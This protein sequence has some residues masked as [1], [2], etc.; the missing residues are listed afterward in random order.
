MMQVMKLQTILKNMNWQKRLARMRVVFGVI[1][2]L[3]PMLIPAATVNVGDYATLTTAIASGTDGDTI[4]FTNNITVSAEV[5][6]NAKGLTIE[7]NNH[8]ISVPVPGLNDSGVTNTSPSVFRV[9]NINASGKTNTLQ[10]MTVKGG[11]P[12]S[13][14]AGFLNTSGTLVLQ[15]VTI[16]QS[17]GP[18]SSGGGVVNNSG[19]LYLRDCNISRNAA[20]YGGGF[21]NYGSGA[22]IFIERCTF[23]ENRSLRSN[24]GG[25][26]GE[27]QS[28]LYANNSTFANNQSTELG[29]AINNYSGTSYCVDCTFVGN[30][31][32]G[33]QMGGAI[34]H[35]GGT[36][37][38]VNCLFAYNYHFNGSTFDLNDIYNYSGTAPL[39]YY[40]IF[41]STTNQLGS[42]SV[43]TTLYPGNISGTNDTLFCGGAT[44]KVLGPDGTEVGTTTIYQPYLALV[45]AS[46]TPTAV[47][48][49]GSFAFG[50]G[51]RAAFSSAQSIPVVGY[52]NGSV[53]VTLLGS[54]PAS[55]EITADQNGTARG[56]SN[57]VGSVNSTATGLFMLKV[58]AT[59][60]GS[61][62]G[63]TIYGD[64]YPSGTTVTLTAIPAAGYAFS[65]WAYVLGGSGVA[66]TANCFAITLTTNVTLLPVF[67][68][69]TGFT[70]SYSGNGFS[71]GTVP[72]A[73]A[74]G[75][76]G[77]TN[78]SDP[79]TMVKSGYAFTNWN[80][81]SDGN[82]TDYAPGAAYSGPGNLNLYA[83]W[84]LLSSPTITTPPISQ[85]VAAGGSVHL[86][87]SATG[88]GP[89]SY[90]WFKN[91][92]MV[93]GATNSALT[94]SSAG[95]TNSGVYYVVVTNA[96]ALSISGPARVTIGA[97]QLLAWGD[98]Q[99][100]QLGDGTTNSRSLPES[101]VG[102]VVIAVAGDAHTLYVKSDGTLWAM[103]DNSFGQL[104]D[105]TT[106][107]RTSPLSVASNVVSV[108]AGTGHS[109]YVK[110]D[111]TL[112]AMGR[113]ND[114]QL[115][116]GTTNDCHS[117][118]SVGTNVVAA[119]AG[120]YDSLFLK[121]DG[122]LWTV[123]NN[124]F[125]QLGD[126]TTL[127]RSNAVPVASNVVA[128]AA[129]V[130][131]SVFLKR[132]GTL[133]AM[134]YNLDGQL[135]NGTTIDSHSPISTASNVVCV[136]AGGYHTLYLKN[137]DT[138]WG[139]GYN[140]NGELGD[141]T[142]TNKHSPEL[143]ASNVAAATGGW[144][145]TLY[146]MNDGT[147]WAMGDNTYGELGDGTTTQ[148]TS[149]VS[150][151]GMS[152]ARI[153]SGNAAYHTLAVGTLPP[154]LIT[155]QPNNQTILAG[156][157]VTFT[158][159]ASG[160]GPL[161][162]QWQFNGTNL[163]NATNATCTLASVSLNN[164]GSYAVVVSGPGGSTVS[165]T[166]T[167]AVATTVTVVANPL[168]AGSVTGGGPYLVGSNV[169]LTATASNNWQFS[170]WNDGATNN[171]H[172]ITVPATNSTYTAYFAAVATLI[173]GD[174][175]NAGGSVSG[176]GTFLVGSTNWISAVA[177]NGWIFVGW[178]TGA[179]N[180]PYAI[181]V[182]SNLTV[183]ATFAPAAS[184][185]TFAQPPEGGL[186]TGA[187]TYAIG[188]SARVTATAASGWMFLNWN[189]GVTNNPWTFV[190]PSS[191]TVCTANFARSSMVTAFASPTNAGSVAGGGVYLVGSNAVLTATAS[192]A[193]QFVQWND[194]ITN[195]PRYLTVPATNITYTAT[196]AP[197]ATITLVANPSAGGSV[198]GGGTFLVGTTNWITA[199]A[200]NNWVFV[201]WSDNSTHNPYAIVVASNQ[202]FTAE[203]TAAATVTTLA[204][205]PQ[206]GSTTGD[207]TY[208]IG[209]PATLTA[210]PSNGWV[211]L[212]WN[213]TVTNYVQTGDTNNPLE[214]RVASSVTYVANFAQVENG[215][216]YTVINPKG[217]P[218]AQ[219]IG[220]TGPK[221]DNIVVPSVIG[222]LAV[223]VIGSGAFWWNS[224]SKITVP[225]CVETIEA[226]SMDVGVVE[227]L[228]GAAEGA[229]VAIE[230]GA[231]AEMGEILLGIGVSALLIDY[232]AEM[233]KYLE[234]VQVIAAPTGGGNPT[235]S[236]LYT[237]G[238]TAR[239][240]ANP[241][242]GW[243]F[244][245]WSDGNTNRS[246]TVPVPEHDVT[247]TANYVQLS[248]V[249]GLANPTNA[250]TVTGGGTYEVGTKVW[251]TAVPAEE[252]GT[253]TEWEFRH[254]NDGTTNNPYQITVPNYDVTYTATFEEMVEVEP[255]A[256]PTW[257][258][259]VTG[260]GTY[261]V[262]TEVWL[263]AT[264][265]SGWRFAGWFWENG[266]TNIPS[267]PVWAYPLTKPLSYRAEFV[268]TIQ[269]NGLANPTNAGSVAGSGVYDLDDT[270]ITL[271][272]TASNNW[273]FVGW[274][275]GTTNSPYT[276]PPVTVTNL[277][278][279]TYMAS[280]AA[281]ATITVSANPNVGGSV[282]G[283]GTYLA[284][285]ST[286]LT[287]VATNGWLFTGWNDGT[288]NSP[289]HI[290]VPTT[291]TTYTANFTASSPPIITTSVSGKHANAR[292]ADRSS[293]VDSPSPNQRLEFHHLV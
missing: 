54:S 51:A 249:T 180:N 61:V 242:Q 194:G 134:G 49:P 239:L 7:G 174:N 123:G 197:T 37:T 166:A 48:K 97:P 145:H 69:D 135:G 187:G 58:N 88:T 81:R 68:L 122:T 263:V 219:I 274:N 217:T 119:A 292:V 39:A 199:T 221:T 261:P 288:T 208:A 56:G 28:Y 120:F 169:V 84:T 207:G 252:T 73:Q 271:T 133:W 228:A 149:P 291:N 1:V 164:A 22:R 209:S 40:S 156:S 171:P 57:T 233:F 281:A 186:T 254:W 231:F 232:L 204:V 130:V 163:L 188:S 94:Y 32:Y 151:P 181:V 9:F 127:N 87:V 85:V 142:T 125:G 244:T 33:G 139:M 251:L 216:V 153:I 13:P 184:V 55:Y 167:L 100:G 5:A 30:I 193:W 214:I 42:A 12:S 201:R 182:T 103:G 6:I 53:W 260:K 176:G 144:Y 92:G 18:S 147:L 109:L 34:A 237:A 107:Q 284:G 185:A 148:R 45:G 286:P 101:V 226:G 4:V 210:T 272:A 129:G 175:T 78:L 35:N 38:L 198:T 203:F 128:I 124:S 136:A 220:Y 289:Y 158:V 99:N 141:G 91:G 178:S 96:Y 71:G 131:H 280:F 21:L 191:A 95:V 195:N 275:D 253:G 43:G 277:I 150:V 20:L 235:G 93:L 31:A 160:V 19:T 234:Q 67:I 250:G 102:D 118:V 11:D 162:Y 227:F 82:G 113:N 159:A 200:S 161:A 77:S 111:G 155:G 154:P 112:W 143:V 8:S 63:A 259:Y 46:Q 262:G 270:N 26:A 74:V 25:G 268:Q 70:I 140:R 293:G 229:C 157:S 279:I 52:Y 278:S 276:I 212:N 225:G 41:Q 24:G 267:I 218:E 230:A 146:L 76:G 165:A 66:S 16:A 196:F 98:N 205:P 23:S 75:L 245:S 115:G 105:G 269:V 285:T 15:S 173:V 247:Y 104:G 240:E 189:G 265:F 83:K 59:T 14:G 172:I 152:L 10:N 168:N 50:K 202:T 117:P 290:T 246:H 44:A 223:T 121:G 126:G 89:L 114:G 80:T 3:H 179:T 283:G 257:G 282:T 17:G 213:G 110:S 211:F 90:Q 62:S 248:T 132:D 190:V 72:A 255:E 86:S 183:T 60:N 266:S 2:G 236:G 108:A 222:G 64:N 206:G 287:A 177:S 36:V 273:M 224:F 116:N 47:L 241:N 138:L 29:G 106:N 65:E 256:E 192:N 79:G 170:Y 137:D 238:T 258:G 264:P 243:R 27:N 215:F